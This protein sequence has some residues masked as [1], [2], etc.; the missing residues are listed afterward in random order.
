MKVELDNINFCL[1]S[2]PFPKNNAIFFVHQQLD[3]PPRDVMASYQPPAKPPTSKQQRNLPKFNATTTSQEFFKRWE[4]EPRKHYG[5]VHEALQFARS[6]VF[7]PSSE[8]FNT[9]STTKETYTGKT[10]NVRGPFVPES[11]GIIA[12]VRSIST[13]CTVRRSTGSE[14]R[15]ICLKARPPGC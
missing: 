13:R 1:L 5:D 8:K 9:V 4:T 6:D 14:W 7:V 2:V 3:Y 10:A 11:K 12:R 15:R